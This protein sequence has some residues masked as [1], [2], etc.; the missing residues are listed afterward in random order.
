MTAAGLIAR[1]QESIRH[2]T[3]PWSTVLAFDPDTGR[4]E[5]VTGY[6]TAPETSNIRPTV[7]LCT[8]SDDDR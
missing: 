5:E 2:G 4:Y 6:L 7:T 1:L 3:S 8:D